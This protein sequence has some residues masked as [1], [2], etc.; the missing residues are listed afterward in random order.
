MTNE[1]KTFDDGGPV[2]LFFGFKTDK[3]VHKCKCGWESWNLGC[4]V[5]HSV[6]CGE[7]AYAVIIAENRERGE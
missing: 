1:K 3:M 2:T 6:D 5:D 4:Y 7:S